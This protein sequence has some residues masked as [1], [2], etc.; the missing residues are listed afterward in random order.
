M[1]SNFSSSVKQIITVAAEIAKNQNF[2]FIEPD[3]LI[4][5][6]DTLGELDRFKILYS[7]VPEY[8]NEIERIKKLQNENNNKRP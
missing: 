2:E 4:I 6:T 8:L 1:T 5:A 3:H 7:L